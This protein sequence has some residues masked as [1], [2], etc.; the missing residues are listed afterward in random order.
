MQWWKVQQKPDVHQSI[1]SC[2]SGY[3]EGQA[4]PEGESFLQEEQA[5]ERQSSK[6]ALRVPSR[7]EN[8][9]RC[10]AVEQAGEQSQSS[11]LQDDSAERV[12]GHH[13]QQEQ[14]TVPQGHSHQQ[15]PT[16][17][18]PA[19]QWPQQ[20][21]C[22]ASED[23]GQEGEECKVVLV[24]VA[25]LSDKEEMLSIPVREAT[26]EQL[27]CGVQIKRLLCPRGPERISIMVRDGSIEDSL[28]R[29][30][31]NFSGVLSLICHQNTQ[32]AFHLARWKRG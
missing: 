1:G 28:G 16:H 26:E 22:Q 12:Q 27:N 24:Q 20:R 29:I 9:R 32:C 25:P 8:I 4:S 30:N 21:L 3:T 17:A 10:D 13:A 19:A 7:H 6:Q 15:A 5:T 31:N 18:E 14:G 2:C 11:V 23:D